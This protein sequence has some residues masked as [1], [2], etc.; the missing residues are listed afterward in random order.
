MSAGEGT[1]QDKK[2]TGGL[3]LGILSLI[4]GTI[5]IFFLALL[6]GSIGFLTGAIGTFTSFRKKYTVGTAL[7]AVGLILSL[8][9]FATSPMF[10]WMVGS[11]ALIASA[12]SSKSGP[13]IATAPSQPAP[14]PKR[15]QL[16]GQGTV[17]DTATLMVAG[18]KAPLLGAAATNRAQAEVLQDFLRLQGSRVRCTP[19]GKTA[20]VC[21]TDQGVDVAEAAILNGASKAAA[22]A[23]EK[24]RRRQE[25][26]QA[27][28]LGIWEK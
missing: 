2:S 27:K 3:I 7:G 14:A 26:A 22:N 15:E 18:V 12:S 19:E 11:S 16:E 6:F 20:Y 4:T 25:E 10:W 17:V 8:I 5:S 23:P 24:Y 13:A 21:L 9:G 28:K 1:I